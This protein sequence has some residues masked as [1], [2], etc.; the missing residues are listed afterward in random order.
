MSTIGIWIFEYL[1][2]LGKAVSGFIRK[3]YFAGANMVLEAGFK[4]SEPNQVYYF[5][6]QHI[7]I[8]FTILKDSETEIYMSSCLT[9]CDNLNECIS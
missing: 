2:P 7:M 5:D 4:V 1:L 3:H 8:H 9:G 6:F